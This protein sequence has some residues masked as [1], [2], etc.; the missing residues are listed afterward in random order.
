MLGRDPASARP[1]QFIDVGEPW[2]RRGQSVENASGDQQYV[3]LGLPQRVERS[4]QPLIPRLH[5]L[6]QRLPARPGERENGLSPVTLA[7][8]TIDQA[9]ELQFREHSRQ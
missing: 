6:S 1:L 5:V 4:L 8:S 2:C 3:D 9:L 7:A